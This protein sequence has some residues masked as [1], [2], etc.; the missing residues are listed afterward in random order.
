MTERIGRAWLPLS[1]DII[2]AL[3]RADPLYGRERVRYTAQ[4]G[5]ERGECEDCERPMVISAA[6]RDD[7]TWRERGYARHA[8]GRRCNTCYTKWRYRNGTSVRS[9]GRSTQ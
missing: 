2:A 6:F 9:R 3:R 8:A 7:P 1:P 5:P 4:D